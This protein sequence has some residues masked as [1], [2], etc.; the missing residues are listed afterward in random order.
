MV[1]RKSITRVIERW[2][3]I[4]TSCTESDLEKHLVMLI[5]EALD[6]NP[7]QI[8]SGVNLGRGAVLKAD[9][10]IYQDPAK[11]PVLVVEDKK[12]HPNYANAPELGFADWC[13]DQPLYKQSEFLVI[14]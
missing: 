8:K 11:P 4:P 10:L 7:L 1:T 14:K 6:L 3:K 12:R 2:Q 13:K 9:F 5:W